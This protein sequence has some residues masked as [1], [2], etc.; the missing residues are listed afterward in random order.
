MSPVAFVTG[1]SRGI[2]RA[3]ALALAEVGYDVAVAARTLIDGT[4]RLDDDATTVPGGLDTTVASIEER[5]QQGYAVAMDVL[6]RSSV[7]AAADA[8]WRHFGRIDVLV[9]N[10]IYQ[11]PGSMTPL[12]ELADDEI[13][14]LFEGNV[15][16]QLALIRHL[17]PR[18]IHQD[19]ATIV[20]MISGTAHLTPPGPIG[21]GGWG[22]AYAMT[23]AA[24]ERVAPVL[25]VEHSADGVVVHSVD[26][27]YVRTERAE[28]KAA[29]RG[30]TSGHGDHFT[31]ATPNVIGAA[32]AWLV[33]DPAGAEMA[34]QIVHAQ[35]IALQHH[36]VPDWRS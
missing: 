18:F 20:N 9:N 2:G 31:P 14:R 19:G 32:V 21:R 16:A 35:R 1:A 34:G 22:V 8:V 5:G 33:T 30:D 26:P 28:A 36:L 17:L 6:D 4:A 15:H 3:C 23:K 25:N 10:A 24:L 13:D 27:G 12:L 29:A 11:G 7:L